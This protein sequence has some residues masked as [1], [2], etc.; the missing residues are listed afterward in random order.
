M[1]GQW[2]AEIAKAQWT[3]ADFPMPPSVNHY[4]RH[5]A[6]G[7]FLS[8]SARKYRQTVMATAL[9]QRIPKFTGGVIATLE[10]HPNHIQCD[11]D[12]Y[13]KAFWDAIQSAGILYNDCQVM[14][15]LRFW[16]ERRKRRGIT[17]RIAPIAEAAIVDQ[18]PGWADQS[19]AKMTTTRSSR[20][21]GG[22]NHAKRKRK[23]GPKSGKIVHRSHGGKIAD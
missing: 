15:V 13:E 18:L 22:E 16:G 11:T 20:I 6:K 7:V 3:V 5:T 9:L 17:L 1:M 19:A 4:W 23:S 14:C 8:Q 10:L 2:L 12:N 21:M